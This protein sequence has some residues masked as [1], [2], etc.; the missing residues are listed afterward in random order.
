MKYDHIIIDS[1]NL[2]YRNHYTHTITNIVSK[3][4]LNIGG[5]EGSLFSYQKLYREYATKNTVVWSLFDNAKSTGNVRK[6]I[7]PSYKLNRN[8]QP[9]SFYRA[10]DFYRLLL[11]HYSD[12]NY[13]VYQTGYEADDIAPVII[14]KIPKEE[15]ILLVSEDIDWCRLLSDTDRKISQYMKKEVWT[16]RSFEQQYD[17]KPTEDAIV[18][19]KTIRGDTS[20]NIPVGLPKLPKKILLALIDDYTDI[21]AVRDDLYAIPYMSNTWKEKFKSC[22]ARMSLNHQLVSFI[23]LK[24]SDIQNFIFPSKYNPETLKILYETLQI[25]IDKV[26]KRLYIYLQRKKQGKKSFDDFFQQPITERK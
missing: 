13:V 18:L 14:S 20:D 11:L 3:V 6:L 7:D 8:I 19:Y 9:K 22:F 26:D 4:P 15:S 21:Y 25:P 17:F 24:E 12:N 23:S 1:N 2:F 10:L 5:I 16:T